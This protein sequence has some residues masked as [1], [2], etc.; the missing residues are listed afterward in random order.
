MHFRICRRVALTLNILT[1]K[2]NLKPKGHKE[3]LRVLPVSIALTVAMVLWVSAFVQTHQLVHTKYVS[4]FIYQLNF[5]K[6]FHFVLYCFVLKS[7]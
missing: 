3:T 4:F 5:K 6:L 1:T 2:Q 7:S